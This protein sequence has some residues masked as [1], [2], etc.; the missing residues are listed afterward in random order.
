MFVCFYQRQTFHQVLNE[1]IDEFSPEQDEINSKCP[2]MIPDYERQCYI[3]SKDYQ[4][5]KGSEIR[6]ITHSFFVGF[7][8]FLTPGGVM[9][10]TFGGKSTMAV[11]V[12]LS[13]IA[14]SLFPTFTTFGPSVIA[15][16]RALQGM[17]QGLVFPAAS[18][19]TAQWLP[20]SERTIA[21]GIMY[22]GQF[23]GW[24]LGYFMHKLYNT[25][26]LE[27]RTQFYFCDI[28]GLIWLVL[29]CIFT[30]SRP[31]HCSY[32][33]PAELQNIC[34]SSIAFDRKIGEIPT[35]VPWKEILSSTPVHA[36]V[37]INFAG[38]WLQHTMQ[39]HFKYYLTDVLGLTHQL[40]YDAMEISHSFLGV[41][42]VIW[43]FV[44][45]WLIN[46]NLMDR[47]TNRKL[48]GV[49]SNFLMIPG[50][51][52]ILFADCHGLSV[53]CIYTTLCFIWGPFF[54]SVRTN[55]VDLS[56]HYAGVLNGIVH[57]T[58]GIAAIFTWDFFAFVVEDHSDL[59]EWRTLFLLLSAIL[60]VLSLPYL[61]F[62][63]AEVQSWST[64][65]YSHSTMQ[66]H[67]TISTLRSTVQSRG[68]Q[69]E[70][71]PS[72]PS[73]QFRVPLYNRSESNIELSKSEGQ[74]V[75]PIK[76]YFTF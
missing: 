62:G 4:V 51:I 22:G 43:S 7:L 14:M 36:L 15:F 24:S 44:G 28:L 74:N 64:K 32:I 46:R 75:S 76:R 63:S 53:A 61:W 25:L 41:S 10:D 33:R 11:G 57:T 69:Y 31:S 2:R 50:M 21:T 49:V 47:T 70:Y 58:G 3:S 8:I 9:A 16:G 72:Q 68:T 23:F 38:S 73:V 71:P 34:T 5:W 29:W 27:W 48:F 54:V 6:G 30:F 45:D 66:T 35:Y 17:S 67:G 12:T 52:A 37:F 19:L 56:P 13:T 42:T 65:L 60:S 26:S 20:A 18:A 55:V 39:H 40:S 1:I 59:T